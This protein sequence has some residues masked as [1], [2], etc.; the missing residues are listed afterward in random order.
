MFYTGENEV[1]FHLKQ[2]SAHEWEPVAEEFLGAAKQP[3]LVQNKD[4]RLELIYIGT[5][6]ALYHSAQLGPASPNWFG[7]MPF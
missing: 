3:L 6:D 7:E 4:G 2:T 1:L 5:D